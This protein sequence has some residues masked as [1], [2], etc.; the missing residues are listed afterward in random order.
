MKDE[1]LPVL[2][3]AA[4]RKAAGE[5][6][7]FLRLQRTELV[8]L[9]AAAALAEPSWESGGLNVSALTSVAFLV[10]AIATRIYSASTHPERVWYDARAVAESTKTLAWQY[11]IGGEAFPLGDPES[12]DRFLSRIRELAKRFPA[13]DVP[14][15]ANPDAQVTP[16]IEALRNSGLSHRRTAYRDDRVL[17]QQ[18]WYSRKAD[19]NRTRARQWGRALL[20]SEVL[21]A[22]LGL[23]RGLGL[24]D[25]DWS[26]L[27]AALAAAVLAWRQTKQHENLAESYAV[28]SHDVA[29]LASKLDAPTTEEQWATVVHDSEAAFSREHTV[30]LARRQATRVE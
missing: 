17:D 22:G 3:R 1:D 18:G 19:F 28:T 15:G 21:A 25:V 10:G 6:K 20:A 26:G 13:L 29:A 2:Y 23:L 4:D 14:A 11:A 27:L 16:A 8:A 9:V 7:K 24:F 12:K 30:W 5:Q